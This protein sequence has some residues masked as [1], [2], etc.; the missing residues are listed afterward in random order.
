M[1]LEQNTKWVQGTKQ[2]PNAKKANPTTVEDAM[3]QVAPFVHSQAKK[4]T[5]NH[6]HEYQDF[7]AAGYE[8]VLVAWNKFNGS[9]YQSTG[10]RFSSYAFW[11]IRERMSAYANKTWA[12]QNHTVSLS[13]TQDADE[14]VD[15]HSEAYTMSTDLLDLK[16][17]FS[18]LSE[19]DQKLVELRVSGETFDEIAVELGFDNLHKARQRY[20]QVVATL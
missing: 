20:M 1:E 3:K 5:R 12:F 14:F 13:G 19:I 2:V 15:L 6:Y 16:K 18:K 7:I 10:Y 8:G 4:W 17:S 9:T 11:H